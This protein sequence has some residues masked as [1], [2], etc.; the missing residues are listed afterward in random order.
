MSETPLKQAIRA[1]GYR[2][3]HV[4]AQVGIG[5]TYLSHIV[6]GRRHPSD[7][8]KRQIART[9]GRTGADLGWPEIDPVDQ[10]LEMAA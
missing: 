7:A 5:E 4:A 1:S 2:Q 9:L 8:L 3:N 6:A 10:P